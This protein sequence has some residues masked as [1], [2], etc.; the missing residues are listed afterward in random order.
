MT[1]QQE[2]FLKD[3]E[4]KKAEDEEERYERDMSK[5]EDEE[6][7]DAEDED[8][9]KKEAKLAK[10]VRQLKSELSALKSHIKKAE[11][12]PLIDSILEAKQ[13]LGNIDTRTEYAKLSKLDKTTL[14]ELAG[15]YKEIVSAKTEPRYQVKYANVDKSVNCD[16]IIKRLRGGIY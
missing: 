3:K 6:K 1:D 12:E 9:H 16:S 2:K 14:E 8:D 5:A 11:V 4:S 7:E 15:S 10:Q 13:S